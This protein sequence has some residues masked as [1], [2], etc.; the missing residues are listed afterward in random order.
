MIL[1][2][3]FSCLLIACL[4]L[5]SLTG[6]G[7]KYHRVTGEIVFPDGS[8]VKGLARGQIVFQKV[9]NGA[10]RQRRAVPRPAPSTKTASS[11]SAPTRSPTALRSAITA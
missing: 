5:A 10:M 9:G 8:P 3:H 11:P 1:F 4:T 7:S 2:R 6:C